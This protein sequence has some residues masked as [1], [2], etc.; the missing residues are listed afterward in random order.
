MKLAC[1]N[2]P[3]DLSDETRFVK[4]TFLEHLLSE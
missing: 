2:F 3:T 4:V 1:M